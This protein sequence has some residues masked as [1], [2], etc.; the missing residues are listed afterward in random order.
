MRRGPGASRSSVAA[1]CWSSA[2]LVPFSRWPKPANT[3]EEVDIR[4]RDQVAQRDQEA[5]LGSTCAAV[6]GVG[7]LLGVV[8]RQR[9]ET[10]ASN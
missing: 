3:A 6:F 7:R 9:A 2:L 1:T 4:G 8:D 5:E 10:G